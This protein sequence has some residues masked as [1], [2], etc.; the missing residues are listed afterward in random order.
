MDKERT[1]IEMDLNTMR[2]TRCG[3]G[4]MWQGNPLPFQSFQGNTVCPNCYDQLRRQRN[5]VLQKLRRSK[6]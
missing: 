2:C 4:H 6:K 1:E 3:Q 5:A